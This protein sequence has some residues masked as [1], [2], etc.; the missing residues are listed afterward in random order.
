MI[1]V[2]FVAILKN[3]MFKT[4]PAKRKLKLMCLTFLSFDDLLVLL[5]LLDI[6]IKLLINNCLYTLKFFNATAKLISKFGVSILEYF[7]ILPQIIIL[8]GQSLVF[9]A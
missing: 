1:F 3:F 5:D 4:V 2:Y 6:K 7:V 8:F 9:F